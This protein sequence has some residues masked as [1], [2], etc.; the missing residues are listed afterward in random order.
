MSRYR[1]FGA[2]AVG[3]IAL[4]QASK[5]Y[6]RSVLTEGVPVSFIDGF[7]DWMLV[8]NTG[9]AFSLFSGG[10]GSRIALSLVALVA[11]GAIL[12]MVKSTADRQRGLLI[13]LG[14][15]AGGALGNLIDRI[16]FGKVTDFVLWH[17]GERYWP[18]FNVADIAL[19]IAVPLFLF[20]GYRKERDAEK[21]NT[22]K[23]DEPQKASK[24][25]KGK[26][27]AKAIAKKSVKKTAAE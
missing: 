11:L 4:D 26:R 27:P 17:Y 25:S 13:G 20:Y 15:M 1:L 9:S 14:L 10:L 21:D 2:V 12:W 6:S 5:I 23:A 8:F 7:W 19:V 3:S 16:L 22:E 18:I 24:S